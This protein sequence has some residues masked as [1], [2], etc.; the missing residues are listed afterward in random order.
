[1]SRAPGAGGRSLGGTRLGAPPPPPPGGE[2][3][4]FR[5]VCSS[6][7]LSISPPFFFPD[8]SPS[9]GPRN[10][11]RGP[12]LPRRCPVPW[13]FGA[14]HR[15]IRC[16]FPKAP[17][18]SPAWAPRVPA[19]ALTLREACSTL[20]PFKIL[21]KPGAVG[22]SIKNLNAF[23]P[24]GGVHTRSP[25]SHLGLVPA[26]LAPGNGFMEG[27]FSTDQCGQGWLQDDSR[28]TTPAVQ[29]TRVQSES[30]RSSG[31]GTG[32]PLQYS[33]LENLTD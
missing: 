1:M 8:P 19:L 31:A 13:P 16:F 12:S 5:P 20:R 18:R 27:N 2:K 30:G 3:P 14:S 17:A 23:P 22:F 10:G 11:T 21:K 24:S 32:N 25:Q 6:F 33:C 9:T 7:Q 28:H 26:F 15:P 29:E 4:A